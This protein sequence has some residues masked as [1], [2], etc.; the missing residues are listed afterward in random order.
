MSYS[1]IAWTCTILAGGC[2]LVV[3]ATLGCAL[4]ASV[5]PPTTRSEVYGRCQI[6]ES[7]SRGAVEGPLIQSPLGWAGLAAI[8]R[9][10][11]GGLAYWLHFESTV[12]DSLTTE[13]GRAL[14]VSE[15]EG[16]RWRRGVQ[17]PES[18]LTSRCDLRL[19]TTRL[20]RPV[21]I[22]GWYIEAFLDYCLD[23]MKCSIA[24][25]GAHEGSAG[26]R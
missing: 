22:P 25:S 4:K 2:T 9:R 15:F 20:A 6:V 24:R 18:L 13:S 16:G 7:G 1:G 26:A 23:S 12:E 19:G 5:S 21:V 11:G 17:L 10:Q 8:R 3:A 14:F